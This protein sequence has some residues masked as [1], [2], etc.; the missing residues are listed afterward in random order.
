MYFYEI[1]S[2]IGT[3]EDTERLCKLYPLSRQPQ[4]NS[5]AFAVIHAL[6][7]VENP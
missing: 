4:P 5:H 2:I 3:L 1:S 7:L 6:V